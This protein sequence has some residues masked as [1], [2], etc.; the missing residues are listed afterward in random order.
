[1]A[2]TDKPEKIDSDALQGLTAAELRKLL[3]RAK[4]DGLKR[5]KEEEPQPIT[6]VDRTGPLPLS[7]AQQRLWFLDQFEEKNSRPYYICSSSK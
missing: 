1:M 2:F 4:I 3:E 7:F 5:N 6:V